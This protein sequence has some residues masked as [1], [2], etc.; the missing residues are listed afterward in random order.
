M[1]S[2]RACCSRFSRPKPL[3]ERV[4]QKAAEV[5]VV[6]PMTWSLDTGLAYKRRVSSLA[7]WSN[8]PWRHQFFELRAIVDRFDFTSC[9]P[10]IPSAVSGRGKSA[11]PCY[12]TKAVETISFWKNP[13]ERSPLVEN[14]S[15][16][17]PRSFRSVRYNHDPAIWISIP[18]PAVDSAAGI[19]GSSSARNS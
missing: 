10:V 16:F 9:L 18:P 12:G 1:L 5:R 2:T 3:R 17:S 15:L 14:Q 19:S 8:P 11:S 4:L 6:R 7:G 13:Q